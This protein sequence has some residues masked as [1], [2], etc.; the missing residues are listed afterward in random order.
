MN[1]VIFVGE[2]ALRGKIRMRH[3]TNRLPTPDAAK[4]KRKIACE[5]AMDTSG[6]LSGKWNRAMVDA[7]ANSDELHGNQ[8]RRCRVG[9]L[10]SAFVADGKVA[11][12]NT[13]WWNPESEARWGATRISAAGGSGRGDL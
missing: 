8:D 13:Q 5:D 11:K 2:E 1:R 9:D 6:T 10:H 7:A 12:G 3:Y 4:L